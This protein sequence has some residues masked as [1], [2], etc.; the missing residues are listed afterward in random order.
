M[1]D[2]QLL[3]AIAQRKV[4]HQPVRIETSAKATA[5]AL[6]PVESAACRTLPMPQTVRPREAT[7]G[8]L[9]LA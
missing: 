8:S 5:Q 7:K 6:F 3:T 1:A 2:P 4:G 9:L